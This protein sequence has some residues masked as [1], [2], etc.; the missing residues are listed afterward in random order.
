MRRPCTE[1]NYGFAPEISGSGLAGFLEKACT[2]K[3]F[4][5]NVCGSVPSSPCSSMA[6]ASSAFLG[7]LVSRVLL[8]SVARHTPQTCSVALRYPRNKP[9]PLCRCPERSPAWVSVNVSL[10]PQSR[11]KGGSVRR[12]NDF[13]STS[14]LNNHYKLETH[15][16]MR[17]MR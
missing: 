5:R 3:T 16:V 14:R 15:Q 13:L 8:L 17:V 4:T 10:T 2:Y 9:F 7:H 12:T 6:A 11:S 1:C